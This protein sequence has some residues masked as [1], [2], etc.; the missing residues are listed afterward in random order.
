V[1]VI[2]GTTINICFHGVGVPARELEPGEDAYWIGEAQ[3]ADILDTV[4]SLPSVDLSFDDGNSSDLRI[5]LPALV[6]RGL[7]ARF[8]VLAGRLG[9]SGSLT[10]AEVRVLHDAGMVVGSHGMRHRPWGGLDDE[11]RRVE[12]VEARERI[13]EASGAPVTEA[14]CPLGRYDRRLLADLRRLGYARVYTSDRRR[15]RP[16]AWLQPRYSV[17]SGDD[18]AS[19]R[20]TVTQAPSVIEGV[21]SAAV[22]LAKRVR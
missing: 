8:F 20:R 6:S 15:A 4:G 16:G 13:G 21:R 18:G 1:N 5:A 3:F 22:G 2:A 7:V 17:R 10:A 12:L 14:A 11:A 9:A 19:I